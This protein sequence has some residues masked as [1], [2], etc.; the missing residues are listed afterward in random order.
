MRPLCGL[1]IVVL[2]LAGCS[3]AAPTPTAA[4]THAPTPTREITPVPLILTP[5]AAPA[6]LPALPPLTESRSSKPLVVSGT[7]LVTTNPDSAS[8]TMVDTTSLSVQAEIPLGGSP[9]AVALDGDQVLVT[10][11]DK[12]A[13]A[14]VS[15]SERRLQTT[16][17]IG[18]MPYGVVTG[19]GRAYV[20]LFADDAIAV[21]DLATQAI[22]YRVAVPDAPTGLALSGSWLLAAHQTSG[23]VT[24]INVERTPFV[25]GSVEAE[26]DG[27]LARTI[28]LAPDGLSA[29]IPQ[30]RTGLALISLQYMQDWFPVV[31]VL[32]LA[33]GTGDRD[34]RLTISTLDQA[35]NMPSDAAFSPDSRTLYVALAGSDAVL[36]IDLETG[37]VQAR[38]AVGA[39]PVG[40]WLA[41]DDLFVLNALDGTVSVIDRQTN[42]VSLVI[43]VTDIPLDPL[44][45]RGKVLFNRASAPQMSDGAVSCATCHPDGGMDGRTWINFRSGP[46]NTPALSGLV[47][48]YNWAGDMAELQDTIEDQIRHV[49]VGDGL[50][51]G[52]FDAT[53]PT[54]DAG[55]S[56]D[57]DALAAYVASLALP[58]SPYRLD[59]GSLS[60]AAR[61]GMEIFMSG[62]PDCS[63]HAPPLYTDALQHNLSGAGFSLEQYEAFDTPTLRGLWASAPYMHDGVVQSL[64]ELLTRTDSVHMVA[65]RLTEGQLDDLIAFLLSL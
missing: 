36:V 28:I 12:N 15:L 11:W 18:H 50:L 61:R 56:A 52:A 49:M 6:A 59:D 45:L 44:I 42:S 16:I 31:S 25:V 3:G 63:C 27:E 10:L 51:D 26:R 35:A 40:L 47:A 22:L 8:L 62:S 30:T 2:L 13:V 48:P 1:V 4:A 64:R 39:N 14:V 54:Q 17:P 55:R 43:H 20:S 46:R 32:D 34:R 21:V 19:S 38:I 37:D 9:R 24:L 53:L 60:D 41:G 65:N 29:Y 33:N 7:T 23:T 57:L 5:I 58:P